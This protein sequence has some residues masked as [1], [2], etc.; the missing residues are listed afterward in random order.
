MLIERIVQGDQLALRTLFARHHTRV[1]RFVLRLTR[2]ESI[3]ED[4]LNDVFL[5]VWRRAAQFEGRAAV[6]S[7]L[8][9]AARF[10]ALS[11]MRRRTD[12]PWNEGLA[13]SIA[14]PAD[15]PEMALQQKD[16]AE[17]LRQGLVKLTPAHS[18]VIDLVYYHGKTVEEVAQIAGVSA[19][20]VKTRMLYARKKLAA[21]VLH[22][23]P[24][25]GRKHVH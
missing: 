25:A 12:L 10:K 21:F 6:S 22:E 23:N 11:A 24:D 13:A 3:A 5:D 18:E 7:W 19:A 14:D 15:D 1:F 20:T 16:R 17:S 9:G 4:V 8:L 2:D